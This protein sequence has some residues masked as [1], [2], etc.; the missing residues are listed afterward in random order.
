MNKKTFTKLIEGTRYSLPH[1]EV[2]DEGL[3]QTENE[4]VLQFVR[5]SQLGEGIEKQEGILIEALLAM[6]IS[7]LRYKST[8]VPS[9]QTAIAITK[10]EEAAMWLENRSKDREE[11]GVQ[12]TYKK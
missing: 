4:H 12:D 1:Y 8:L 2:T 3:K 6:L 10:L 9:R 11:R 5:G 7:D